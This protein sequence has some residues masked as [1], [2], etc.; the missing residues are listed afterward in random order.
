[1]EGPHADALR[2]CAILSASIGRSCAEPKAEAR[3]APFFDHHLP[4][5]LD[6]SRRW[7]DLASRPDLSAGERASLESI[8]AT[9]LSLPDLFSAHAKACRSVEL[10]D[11]EHVDAVVR[12]VAL[13]FEFPSLSFPPEAPEGKAPAPFSVLPFPEARPTFRPAAGTRRKTPSVDP[14]DASKAAEGSKAA[15][16]TYLRAGLLAAAIAAAWALIPSKADPAKEPA[17]KAA[18][19]AVGVH[20]LY[21]RSAAFRSGRAEVFDGGRSPSGNVSA[22][23]WNGT[24]VAAPE[25]EGREFSVGIRSI[26]G[27]SCRPLIQS[28]AAASDAVGFA[29]R[30]GSSA[31]EARFADPSEAASVC[32]VGS[33]DLVEVVAYYPAPKAP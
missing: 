33:S 11:L 30:G 29:V 23:G 6:L 21:G 4:R 18:I 1:M 3:A 26:P 7:A 27:P 28:L 19:V 10:A 24:I 31:V 22:S 13:G 9:I 2:R 25:S 16:W 15:A 5:S 12:T 8:G 20:D 14:P 17:R 32:P